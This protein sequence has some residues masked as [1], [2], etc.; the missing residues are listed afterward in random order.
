[1]QSEAGAIGAIHGSL[2]T[3]ALSTTYTSSQ[4]LLLMI[5]VLHRIAGERH[6]G[7]IHV[8]ARTVGTHAM[9]I[10]GD[11]SDVMNCRQT[12][13]AML[14]SS[15]VQEVMDL[16]GIAHLAA[17][18]CRIPFMHFFDGFRTSHEISKIE[19]IDYEEFKNLIDYNA[20]DEFRAHALNPEHP[21]LRA[22][23]Q[24]PDVYFQVREANN[25]FYDAVPGIVEDYM[26]KINKIT[27]RNYQLFNYYGDPEADRVIVAMGSVSETICQTVDYLNGLGEKVGFVQVHLYRPFSCEHL[28]NA[29][30]VTA[31]KIAVLDRCKEMG[32]A[33]EPL[34][35]DICTAFINSERNPLIIGGR[36]GL[37]SKDTDPAQIKATF[38]NLLKEK[39]KHN[40]TIGIVD[41]ITHLSLPIVYNVL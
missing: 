38:D 25:R 30:P 39:P 5:P 31:T 19:A 32:S 36:Y 7:V 23:V 35:Q 16:A 6:P 15:G 21:T 12:G 17:I 22:T 8:A 29:I 41:D 14:A 33:G 10:F 34:F 3:G 28:L 26:H 40:F 2:E 24:N 37:S 27:G 1:M 18:K 13:F 4:G 20:L 9:S 11:H